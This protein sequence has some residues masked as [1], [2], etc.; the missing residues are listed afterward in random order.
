MRVGLLK[1][2]NLVFG[3][4]IGASLAQADTPPTAPEH[5]VVLKAAHLFDGASG[6]LIDN[7]MVVVE[8][9]KISAVGQRLEVTS[10]RV[11]GYSTSFL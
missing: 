11:S 7:G 1:S 9:K 2:V 5:P 10:R 4:L 6:K 3:L 8:G